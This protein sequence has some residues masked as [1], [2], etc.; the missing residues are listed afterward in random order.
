[1]SSNNIELL[2]LIGLILSGIA[3]V[4]GA[5]TLI[6]FLRYKA[7]NNERERVIKIVQSSYR[8]EEYFKALVPTRN[9]IELKQS[10]IEKIAALVLDNLSHIKNEVIEQTSSIEPVLTTQMV[11][12]LFASACNTN[13]QTFYS[14]SE[15]PSE[16]TI[17]V[18]D[19]D[20]KNGRGKFDLHSSAIE[21]V[22]ECRDFLE[23]ACST[24]G[25]GNH[26]EVIGKGSIVLSNGEWLVEEKMQIKFS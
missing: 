6:I 20:I 22:K 11:Q 2:C 24:S 16:E 18:L 26:I 25:N 8:I 1:M 21:K 9:T 4:V 15:H 17:F 3:I 5:I 7:D 19:V 12:K 10:Q 13:T 23:G 14:V